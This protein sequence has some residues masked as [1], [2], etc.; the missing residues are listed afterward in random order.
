MA[1]D[2]EVAAALGQGTSAPPSTVRLYIARHGLGE[3]LER[4]RREAV[5]SLEEVVAAIR[6]GGGGAAAAR[7]LGVS[8]DQVAWVLRKNGLGV[9]EVLSGEAPSPDS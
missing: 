6:R 3:A 5:L 4:A 2:A 1:A 8:R 9:R 7:E